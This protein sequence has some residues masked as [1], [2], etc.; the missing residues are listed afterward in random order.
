MVLYRRLWWYLEEA[1]QNGDFGFLDRKDFNGQDLFD[2]YERNWYII[3]RDVT[4]PNSWWLA[5]GIYVAKFT[6]QEAAP[7]QR[8]CKLKTQDA[9]IFSS[10]IARYVFATPSN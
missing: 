5:F 9:S 4:L 1:N 8:A 2:V 6:K 3:L 10:S 7:Q